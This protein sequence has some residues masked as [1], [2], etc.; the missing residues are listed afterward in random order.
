[1][2]QRI[3]G[4][5]FL[6]AGILSLRTQSALAQTREDCLTCHSDKD[7]TKEG[8]GKKT[9]SLY[10]DESILN[11]STHAKLACVACHVGFNPD[12]LPH[13]AKIEPVSCQRCHAKAVFKHPFHRDLAS[14]LESGADTRGTV[15]G[16]PRH[17]QRRIAEDSRGK[18]FCG[19]PDEIL[20]IVP[21][22]GSESLSSVGPRQG[23]CRRREGGAKLPDL[24]PEHGGL[25]G[26]HHRHALGQAGS[27][28]ALSVVSSRRP[29]RAGADIA[30]GGIHCRVRHQR[31][32]RRPAEG[33][34]EGRQLRQLSRQPRHEEGE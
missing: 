32:R 18:V 7:L 11:K 6:L 3:L 5:V 8:P 24:P 16:M 20:R 33:Q 21:Q 12:D 25:R 34:R 23:A 26:G 13:K 17:P 2:R 28:A 10:A 22:G 30:H 27:G 15:R 14:G 9:I 29:R 19:A 1:M 4:V 31:T